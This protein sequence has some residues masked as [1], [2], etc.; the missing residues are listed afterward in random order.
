MNNYLQNI[1]VGNLLNNINVGIANEPRILPPQRDPFA[2]SDG[3]FI[4]IFKLNKGLA[5]NVIDVVQRYTQT[6]QRMTRS[7]L[8]AR[9]ITL[10]ALKFFATGSYQ[11]DIGCNHFTSVGQASTSRSIH[12]VIDVLNREDIVQEWIW[13]PRTEIEVTEKVKRS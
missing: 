9:K 3:K 11:R 13:F 1:L 6:A 5:E 4:Q 2:E 12:H 10:T 7:R 8:G